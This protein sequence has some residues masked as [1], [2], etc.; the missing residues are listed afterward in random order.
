MPVIRLPDALRRYAGGVA[1]IEVPG[2]TMAEALAAAFVAYPDLRLRLVD[3]SGRV[4]PYLAV[5]HNEAEL[6]RDG[7]GETTLAP[8]DCLTFLEAIGGG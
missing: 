4:Y 8:G 2:G 7:M 6:P 5:F 1:S 3:E